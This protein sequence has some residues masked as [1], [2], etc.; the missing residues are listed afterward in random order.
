MIREIHERGRFLMTPT[1]ARVVNIRPGDIVK[2]S[3]G[4]QGNT[5]IR[6]VTGY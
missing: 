6:Q 4:K 3:E 5:F 2:S 1:S